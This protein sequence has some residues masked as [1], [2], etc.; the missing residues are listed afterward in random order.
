MRIVESAS[1]AQGLPPERMIEIVVRAE[2]VPLYLEELTK[3]VLESSAASES[4]STDATR[5]RPAPSSR[6]R[7]AT[8][9]WP[10]STGSVPRSG[11]SSPQ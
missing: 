5:R 4:G 8:R 3:A 7:C 6:R 10:A 1:P 11:R 9:S 2:G